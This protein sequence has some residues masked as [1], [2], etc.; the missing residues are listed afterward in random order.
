MWAGHNAD[1]TY[2]DDLK[3]PATAINP[4]GQASDS[5]WDTTIAGWLF[6][7]SGTEILAIIEQFPHA[8]KEGSTFRPHVHWQK[9]TSASGDVMWELKYRWA[10]I[11]EVMDGSW[12]T[13]TESD[14]VAGTTDNDTE[15][16][17]LITS[18]GDVTASGKGISDMLIMHLSRLGSD[19]ADTYGADARLLEF[20]IH[21]QRDDPGSIQEYSKT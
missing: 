15:D 4:P 7:A 14:P 10:P 13:L 3:S 12:T 5:D 17:H 20:D 16:E 18:F 2:W 9:T 6:A 1:T 21:Y 11:G 19:A 8:W